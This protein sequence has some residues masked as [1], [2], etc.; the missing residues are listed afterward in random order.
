MNGTS[1]AVDV[2]TEAFEKAAVEGTSIIFDLDPPVITEQSYQRGVDG[3][4]KNLCGNYDA[5]WSCPPNVGSKDEV[6]SRYG[7]F[8]RCALVPVEIVGSGEQSY[9]EADGRLHEICLALLRAM[10]SA[11][12][13]AL[14]LAGGPCRTCA[15]C[16][17][18]EPCRRPEEK[19]PSASG[20]G[21]PI[22]D[23]VESMGLKARDEGPGRLYGLILY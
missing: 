20:Y 10:N 21:V 23:Y 4:S 18:P 13:E 14:A 16:A 12:I 15:E 19:I 11:K 8:Q 22:L 9:R 5:N 6:L 3:C 2:L 17:Y 7:R 1:I